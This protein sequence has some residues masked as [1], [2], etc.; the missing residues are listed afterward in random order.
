MNDTKEIEIKKKREEL[1]KL[2]DQVNVL[3]N[4]SCTI[5]LSDSNFEEKQKDFVV[6]F[7]S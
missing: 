5:S 4:L 2:S 3:L 1:R 6:K 7:I